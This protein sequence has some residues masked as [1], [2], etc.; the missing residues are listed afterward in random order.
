MPAPDKTKKPKKLD[1]G[2]KSELG[3]KKKSSGNLMIILSVVGVV[4][5]VAVGITIY[6]LTSGNDKPALPPVKNMAQ[7]TGNTKGGAEQPGNTGGEGGE[8]MPFNLAEIT[9]KINDL[10]DKLSDKTKKDE[11]AKALKDMLE[12]DLIK[13]V[14]DGKNLLLTAIMQKAKAGNEGAVDFLKQL[15]KDSSNASLAQLARKMYDDNLRKENEQSL[16]VEIEAGEEPTLFIPNKADVVFSMRMSKFLD[17]DFN[18]AVFTTGA[19]KQEDVNKR[20]GMPANTV[21]QFIVSGMKDFNQVAAVVR[22]TNPMNWDDIKKTMQ[23]EESGTTIKGKTYY[24]GKIDFMTEFLGKRVPGIE[25]LRDKAAFWRVDTRTFV[26]ADETTMKD[27]LENPPEKDKVSITPPASSGLSGGDG[28]AI[29]PTGA[30]AGGRGLAS[31]GAGGSGETPTGAGGG[32][33]LGNNRGNRG[34]DGAA[35]PGGDAAAGNAGADKGEKPGVPVRTERFLTI[36]QKLRRLIKLTEDNDK[37]SLI[38]YA[39]KAT[40][41]FPVLM[42]YV[43]YLEQLPST[44]SK[45]ID[46][47]AIA[48]PA[49]TG[50]PALRLGVACK[51]RTV[52]RDVSAEIEKLLA[53]IGKEDMRDLFGFDFKMVQAHGDTQTNTGG[54]GGRFGGDAGGG[55]TGGMSIGGNGGRIG[56]GDGG[57]RA[58]GGGGRGGPPPGVGRKLQAAV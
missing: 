21:D 56:G 41:K 18:R 38:V 42:N 50:S 43:Q 16:S 1:K 28:G 19:F 6:F 25:A 33:T 45:E 36:D 48:L 32:I 44:K 29:P 46:S 39:D 24:L 54:G 57:G 30:P 8:A 26:Y 40:S 20:L 14:P 22:T 35:A 34:G 49:V 10:I 53:R 3:K 47:L 11:A 52:V 55:G 51:S 31:Q 2:K 58:V 15:A 4:V 9:A 5:L 12:G 37:E 27:L 13:K 17:S 23:M 7:G